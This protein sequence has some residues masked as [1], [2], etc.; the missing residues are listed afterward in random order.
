MYRIEPMPVLIFLLFFTWIVDL[1]CPKLKAA[2]RLV[3]DLILSEKGLILE[4]C[5]HEKPR[6]VYHIY[7]SSFNEIDLL[8]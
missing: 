8:W 6:T 2:T 1:V 3:Q 7:L 5:Y 4:D